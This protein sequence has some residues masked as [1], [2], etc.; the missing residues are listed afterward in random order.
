VPGIRELKVPLSTPVT[1]SHR[2][3]TNLR[4]PP[5]LPWGFEPLDSP[6][7]YA[8]VCEKLLMGLSVS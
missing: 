2:I 7:G 6:A 5:D 4:G 1:F 3:C 8:P